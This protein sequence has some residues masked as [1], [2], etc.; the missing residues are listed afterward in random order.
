MYNRK[1]NYF[2]SAK[3]LDIELFRPAGGPTFMWLCPN[4]ARGSAPQTPLGGTPSQTHPCGGCRPSI[5]LFLFWKLSSGLRRNA[6]IICS[7]V[8]NV[9]VSNE[10]IRG[11][12][13][14]GL[15]PST[16]L[17]KVYLERIYLNVILIKSYFNIGY[18]SCRL[19]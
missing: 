12:S 7:A 11:F 15:R 17:P 14:M 10:G 8:Y 6:I 1:I 19:F 16:P 2:I 18:Y 3:D 9:N 13:F 4:P 5:P